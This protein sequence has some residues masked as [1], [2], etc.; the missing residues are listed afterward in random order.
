MPACKT[1]L[2]CLCQPI[3]LSSCVCVSLYDCHPVLE[4][5][6]KT[7]LMC[8]CQPVRLSSVLLQLYKS[9]GCELDPD[10][11][12]QDCEPPL[13]V[14]TG[15]Y[16]NLFHMGDGLALGDSAYSL[17]AQ[18]HTPPPRAHRTRQA[19][20]PTTLHVACPPSPRQC[21]VA[22][23]MATPDHFSPSPPTTGH[24]L[25][26]RLVP[27]SPSAAARSRPLPNDAKYPTTQ[28]LITD[29]DRHMPLCRSQHSSRDNLSKS[30]PGGSTNT[31]G[32]Y[33]PQPIVNGNNIRD[34]GPR[35]ALPRHKESGYSSATTV[36]AGGV[37]SQPLPPRDS[38][39]AMSQ[40]PSQG[41]HTVMSQPLRDSHAVMS[42]PQRDGHAVMSQHQRDGHAVMSQHQRD[43]HAV[44]SQPPRDNHSLGVGIRN[45]PG[46]VMRPMSFVRAME[47][48]DS[49]A[50]QDRTQHGRRPP[51]PPRGMRDD[52][53]REE[54]TDVSQ[55]MYGSNYEISV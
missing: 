26:L 51:P 6:Y 29:S 25:P 52:A 19:A 5:A 33:A 3:R 23:P 2:L 49:L 16:S 47:M 32:L 11:Q 10:S 34:L 15:S 9:P 45:V 30:P 48:S 13:P 50:L 44:M 21:R 1:A 55:A 54:E 42:Q 4:P 17:R 40:P 53:L 24:D 46:A 7:V 35:H 22:A 38:H 31:G 18:P 39:A 20:P 12:S 43:G 8:L 41:S 36:S 28:A 27:Q 14:N 37:V